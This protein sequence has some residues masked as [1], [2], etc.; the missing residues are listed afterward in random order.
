VEF[1]KRRDYAN[2][3]VSVIDSRK[4]EKTKLK[5]I[6]QPLGA[7]KTPYC[8]GSS[9]FQRTRLFPF[10]FENPRNTVKSVAALLSGKSKKNNLALCPQKLLIHVF[11]MI[12][13]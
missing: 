10:P 13:N 8:T 9:S 3:Q 4:L 7:P 6:N 12:I 2:Q 1:E 5:S 11:D